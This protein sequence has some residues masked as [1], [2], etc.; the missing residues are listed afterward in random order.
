M[1]V[2]RSRWFAFATTTLSLAAL[3][4]AA[5]SLLRIEQFGTSATD[6]PNAAAP[7]GAGEVYASGWTDGSLGGP[8]SGAR[9]AWSVFWCEDQDG[10]GAHELFVESGTTAVLLAYAHPERD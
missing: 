1:S 10:N 9:D 7:D 3:S 8:T 4:A 2:T 6:V 5:Q